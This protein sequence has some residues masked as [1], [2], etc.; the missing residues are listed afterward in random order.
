[1]DQD[2]ISAPTRLEK[3]RNYMKE[4]PNV[5]VVGTA[6]IIIDPA[7]K[8]LSREAVLEENDILQRAL[9]VTNIFFHGSVMLKNNVLLEVG[10]YSDTAYLA[11]DYDAWVR[12]GLVGTMANIQEPLYYWRS[13]GGGMSNQ[14]LTK[15]QKKASELGQKVWARFAPDGPAPAGFGEIIVR[16]AKRKS[17]GAR[18]KYSLLFLQFSRSYFLQGDRKV[19]LRNAIKAIR[20][21]PSLSLPYFYLV[22]ILLLPPK[23]FLAFESQAVRLARKGRGY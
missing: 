8:H 1:M 3:Q 21:L 20:I 5:T 22:S 7:G 2:D 10:G 23:L 13:H 15:Q 6:A 12:L 14:N 11:E 9:A 17:I 19:A 16:G 4:N 18:K